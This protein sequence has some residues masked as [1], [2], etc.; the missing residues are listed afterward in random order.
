MGGPHKLK[1]LRAVS[2]YGG[3][4]GLIG[5]AVYAVA[6]YPYQ[7]IDEYQ[8]IQKI[9]RAGVNQETIQPGGMKVWSDPFD[10]KKN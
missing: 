10:R 7:H 3:L 9:T 5:V 2:F 1:G 4:F 8:K 6:I